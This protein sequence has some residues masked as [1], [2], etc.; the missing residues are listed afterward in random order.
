MIIATNRNQYRQISRFVW[1][2]FLSHRLCFRRKPSP[3]QDIG[4]IKQ[5][6]GD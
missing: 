5:N 4:I 3:I 6:K 1:V 2:L